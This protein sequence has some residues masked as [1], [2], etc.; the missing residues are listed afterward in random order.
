MNNVSFDLWVTNDDDHDG[1]AIQLRGKRSRP[2]TQKLSSYMP[3]EII[4]L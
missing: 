3:N 2:F 1:S 4:S